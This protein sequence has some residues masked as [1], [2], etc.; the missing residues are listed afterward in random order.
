MKN[1]KK[2]LLPKL[3]DGGMLNGISQGILSGIGNAILPGIGGMLLPQLGNMLTKGKNPFKLYNDG[4]Y[5][6]QYSGP[7]HEKGGILVNQNGKKDDVNPIAEVEGGESGLKTKS[8]VYVFSD[9]LVNPSSGNTFSKDAKRINNKY[10]GTDR[11]AIN[12]RKKEYAKLQ[13]LNEAV[14]TQTDSGLLPK[15]DV[16]G[17]LGKGEINNTVATDQELQLGKSLMTSSS[18]PKTESALPKPEIKNPV[19]KSQVKSTTNS[20]PVTQKKA[21]DIKTAQYP[22]TNTKPKSVSAKQRELSNE[23]LKTIQQQFP[24]FDPNEWRKH[25]QSVQVTSSP[26]ETA[27]FGFLGAK[28]LV[29]TVG[30]GV[31]I[32]KALGAAKKEKA[33]AYDDLVSQLV[34]SAKTPNKGTVSEAKI[35]QT[36]PLTKKQQYDKLFGF[37]NGG[38]LPKFDP[39]GPLSWGQGTQFNINSG[40]PLMGRLNVNQMLEG[41]NA[42]TYI[43]PMAS[44]LPSISTLK[45][46]LTPN[47][48]GLFSKTGL[49]YK[50]GKLSGINVTP[51]LNKDGVTTTNPGSID[52]TAGRSNPLSQS[53]IG[54]LMKAGAYGMNLMDALRKPEREKLQLPDF[55]KGNR[56][57]Q[58]TGMSMEPM[59]QEINMQ[60]NKALDMAK[61]ASGSF[62][63]YMSRANSILGQSGKQLAES[64]LSQK[65]YND[66]LALTKA[67]RQDQLSQLNQTERIRK[68]NADS[69]NVAMK[70]DMVANF[71]TNLN[72][73]GTEF[74]K[75]DYLKSELA[76][77]NQKQ[78]QD[79]MV[80]LATANAI[81]PNFQLDKQALDKALSE[82]NLEGIMKAITFVK[83]NGGLIPKLK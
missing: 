32:L 49:Q 50:D 4:G 81:N 63:Q 29:T 1:K 21:T 67:G 75:Q 73:L 14:R 16:G 59:R 35:P 22:V 3:P 72:N 83:R 13:G 9:H 45:Q 31:K 69:A 10:K 27:L 20:T 2:K 70:Q 17:K 55:G 68:Q 26:I 60:A 46:T 12:A 25:S 74:Q 18:K 54:G 28:G 39:G 19:E 51:M 33:Q 64:Q 37:K 6:I 78:K 44:M 56:L 38:Q 57:V 36:K 65:Q 11:M 43:N 53:T 40:N 8:G 47:I 34:D 62:G 7:K 58:G 79:F 5:L 52:V 41:E 66:Q 76:N 61:S 23:E 80:K 24:N 77:L 42:P 48:N 71:Y 15:F 30:Q 82:D